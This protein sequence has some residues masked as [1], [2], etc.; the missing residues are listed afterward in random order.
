MSDTAQTDMTAF[1]QRHDR[2]SRRL[3]VAMICASVVV[4]VVIFTLGL[5]TR[6]SPAA[7]GKLWFP[8]LVYPALFAVFWIAVTI[9]KRK[10]PRPPGGFLM[11]P[12][13]ARNVARVANGGFAFVVGF[14]AVNIASQV[15]IALEIFGVLPALYDDGAWEGR[16]ILAAIGILTAYFGNA[17]SRMPVPRA[18]DQQPAT[19]MKFKRLFAWLIVIHG[20]LLA[21]AALFLPIQAMIAA[22]LVVCCSLMLS[23]AASVVIFRKA[24]KR[25]GRLVTG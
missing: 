2:K 25:P 6:A 15:A 9:W 20:L 7:F 12:D 21:L 23:M 18:P 11:N 17:W 4:S 13:D 8:I 24:L 10:Q 1:L 14:A 5:Q 19:Q 16:A 22:T 3:F